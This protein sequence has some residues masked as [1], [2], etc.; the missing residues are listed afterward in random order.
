MCADNNNS[1]ANKDTVAE[2][3]FKLDYN[4]ATV[5]GD[6]YALARHITDEMTKNGFWNK[7]LHRLELAAKL[8]LVNTE[9]AELIEADRKGAL[10]DA[11]DKPIVT[12]GGRTITNAEEEVV[13]ILIRVLDIA[14]RL[15]QEH[16]SFDLSEAFVAKMYYNKQ[17]PRKH[18]KR[19]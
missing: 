4:V 15:A 5:L 11:T 13:D 8:A 10:F 6:L 3:L 19:Y 12:A 14:G 16:D 1:H 9:V 2:Y 17:R 18:G 7:K